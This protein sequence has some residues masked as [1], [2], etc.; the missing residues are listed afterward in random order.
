MKRLLLRW[1]IDVGLYPHIYFTYSPFKILEFEALTAPLSWTG[2]ERVLDIGCGTGLQT[3]L[4]GR[5]CGR[6]VGVDVA[7]VAI[8]AARWLA[9]RLGP[10]CPAE[11][12]AATVQE[13][14]FTAATFDRIFSICVIE[15]IAD[16]EAVLAE[17]LRILKPGGT[18]AFTVDTLETITDPALVAAHRRDHQVQRYFRS[19]SLRELL[20]GCGFVVDEMRPLFRSELARTL[21]SRGIV[22]G[23][24]FGRL[25]TGRLTRRLAAAEA[26]QDDPAAPGIFLLARCHKPLPASA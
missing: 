7:P 17:C 19:D 8:T 12:H 10:A 5:R 21:F 18:M 24:N 4:I 1:L 11:F 9:E 15:H 26:A 22:D 14:G 20:T 25:A 23:F 2:R 6:I 16:Y 3:C 13:C